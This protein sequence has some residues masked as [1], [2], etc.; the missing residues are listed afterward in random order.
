M[1]M[2][3][4]AIAPMQESRRRSL[5]AAQSKDKARRSQQRELKTH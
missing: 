2:R 1:Q 5:P 4:R 3:M